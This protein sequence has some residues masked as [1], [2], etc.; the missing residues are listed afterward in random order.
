MK[1]PEWNGFALNRFWRRIH[2]T[3]PPSGGEV[4]LL[5]AMRSIV[6]CKSGEWALEVRETVTPR[7]TPLSVR[8]I[9]IVIDLKLLRSVL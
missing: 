2:F 3:S 7:P 4:D 6:Q 8:L 5:L 1:P 9:M